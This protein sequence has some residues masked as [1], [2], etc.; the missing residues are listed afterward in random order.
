MYPRVVPQRLP[1][2]LDTRLDDERRLARIL[3]ETGDEAPP[4][5]TGST[6]G[7]DPARLRGLPAVGRG[8]SGTM[9]GTGPL[10]AL[11]ANERR[12]RPRT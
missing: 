7:G 12:R 8:V 11:I 3:L 10:A 1:R 9:P 5:A 6:S 4:S 2:F